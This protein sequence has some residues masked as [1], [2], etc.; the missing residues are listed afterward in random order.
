[1]KVISK[2]QEV[3]KTTQ[4]KVG[5]STVLNEESRKKIEKDI[6]MNITAIEQRTCTHCG[7]KIEKD[8]VC[9]KKVIRDHDGIDIFFYCEICESLPYY[10]VI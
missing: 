5:T 10:C 1:M 4:I 9:Y 7:K 3:K 8:D 6:I 2:R